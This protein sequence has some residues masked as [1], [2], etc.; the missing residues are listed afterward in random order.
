[1]KKSLSSV[2]RWTAFS[3]LIKIGAGLFVIKWIALIYGSEGVGQAANYMT[4]LTVLSVFA[5]AGI[6]NGVTKYVA[7][8][9]MQPLQLAEMLGCS[10]WIIISFSLLLALLGLLFAAPLYPAR[11]DP[12]RMGGA[13]GRGTGADPARGGIGSSADRKGLTMRRSGGNGG[14]WPGSYKSP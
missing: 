3:T 13:V 10:T 14:C 9:E 11:E 6:F 2:T 12:R 1:M 5:G 8:Y 4:L 7:E